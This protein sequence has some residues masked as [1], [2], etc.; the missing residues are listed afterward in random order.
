MKRTISLSIILCQVLLGCSQSNTES[1]KPLKTTS[2]G[3]DYNLA[4]PDKVFLLPYD[5]E[6]ISG[7]SYF[8]DSIIVAV[9]DEVGKLFFYDYRQGKL[10]DDFSFGSEGDYEGVEVVDTMIYTVKSNGRLYAINTLTKEV[11]QVKTKLTSKNNVEGLAYDSKNHQLILAC[12][13]SPSIGGKTQKGRAFYAYNLSTEEFSNKPLF[14]VTKK[15][16]KSFFEKESVEIAVTEFKPSGIAIH[17]I[18]G[19][20]YIL[21]HGGRLLVVLNQRYEII[22]ASSLRHR[23]FRQPEGICFTPE[24]DLMISN[25]GQKDRATLLYYKYI[26]QK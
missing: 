14:D 12:K 9:Q 25:E 17:P 21:A 18:T 16:I 23:L 2:V 6:E 19:Q 22:G 11:Y 26:N 13:A 5:L 3:I 7:L 1:S 8:R 4:S 24:G 20:I 10:L 15:E